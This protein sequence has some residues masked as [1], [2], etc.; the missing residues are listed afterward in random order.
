MRE[1]ENVREDIN[2]LIWFLLRCTA[3]GREGWY[4]YT[5]YSVRHGCQELDNRI[6]LGNTT[7]TQPVYNLNAM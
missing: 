6:K 1:E 2:G 5:N 7:L 4:G 3:F